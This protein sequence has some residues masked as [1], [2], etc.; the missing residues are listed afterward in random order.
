MQGQGHIPEGC[1]PVCIQPVQG[2]NSPDVY[3]V[4]GYESTESKLSFVSH[5]PGRGSAHVFFVNDAHKCFVKAFSAKGC[6]FLMCHSSKGA[7][8]GSTCACCKTV[9][10][11]ITN[12]AYLSQK[13]PNLQDPSKPATSRKPVHDQIIVP[14]VHHWPAE[15]SPL[16][17][18]GHWYRGRH[19]QKPVID[20]S[21]SEACISPHCPEGFERVPRGK[22]T[23]I[24]LH[25]AEEV[26]LY[27]CVNEI[28][29]EILT[30]GPE[31]GIF[32]ATPP[33]GT[34][35]YAYD[36]KWMY[37]VTMALFDC[38]SSLQTQYELLE[39]QHKRGL[40][41]LEGGFEYS[42]TPSHLPT[43]SQFSN[44]WHRFVY[45]SV[46]WLACVFFSQAH[47]TPAHEGVFEWASMQ[48]MNTSRA[49]TNIMCSH[50]HCLYS[51]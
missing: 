11:V 23:L 31:Q 15:M 28:T 29:G 33:G 10:K 22:C 30:V 34:T 35:I 8:T 9:Y 13:F 18:V 21:N 14:D 50:N 43:Y 27:D 44:H 49:Y 16:I 37:A 6:W 25:F 24:G 26:M 1:G 40:R 41:A 12:S 38:G 20:A 2:C 3:Y 46:S 17:D 48:L 42:H 7:H 47:Y 19:L 51:P 32:I 4:S 39:V 5:S 36:A 45:S